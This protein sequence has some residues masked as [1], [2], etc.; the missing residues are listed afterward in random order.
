MCF[1][2]NKILRTGGTS[3]CRIANADGKVWLMPEQGMQ[4]AMNLYQPSGIK[5]KT[6]KRFFPYLY[7]IRFVRRTIEAERMTC[8]LQEDIR[9]LLCHIF[10]TPDLEFAIFCGTPCVHQKITIQIFNGKQ[11]LGYCKVSD[12]QEISKL[13][14]SETEVL[15]FLKKQGMTG[16]PECLYCGKIDGNATL[17]VQSTT[18]T[19]HSSVLHEWNAL[20]ETFLLNLQQRTL[21]SIPFEESDYYRTIQALQQ[22]FDWVPECGRIIISKTMKRVINKY[23]SKQVAYSA[24]HADFTPWNIFVEDGKLFVFDWEYAQLTYPPLLDRYH[25]FT[26]TAHFE[27]HWTPTEII[28]YI[29]STEG[30]WIDREMYILYLLE[31]VSRFT[32]REKGHIMGDVSKSFAIWINLLEYLQE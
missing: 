31:V 14:E 25:F 18:K 20:H 7:R 27:K 12:N 28:V 9:N 5:G 15:H 1:L 32:I 13:F 17:F 19:Q 2:L 16:I 4:V 11:I 24:Y 23:G 26:Q 3:F 6:L 21:Q 29:N 30:K 10:Q 8:S 22:H